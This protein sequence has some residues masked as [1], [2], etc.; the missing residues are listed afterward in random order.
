MNSMIFFVF[1]IGI[2]LI[3]S[4]IQSVFGFGFSLLIMAILPQ[5]MPMNTAVIYNLTL[6]LISNLILAIRFR[7]A[8]AW[9]ELLPMLIPT[10]IVCV[11]TAIWAVHIDTVLMYLLLGIMLFASALYFFMFSDRIHVRATTGSGIGMGVICGFLGGLFSLAGPAAALYLMPAL[12]DKDRFAATIQVYFVC[13]NLVN[14]GTRICM[15]TFLLEDIP[16]LS[17]CAIVMVIGTLIG[18]SLHTK[19]R[20][21]WFKR[22]V[23]ALVGINGI[24]IILNYIVF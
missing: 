15:G 13:L 23:Y 18:I 9:K 8:I 21:A 3:A 5:F 17:I 19:I 4:M 14:L 12:E 10:L 1:L 22:A 16:R 6:A 2:V 24:W 20:G 11:F 7:K